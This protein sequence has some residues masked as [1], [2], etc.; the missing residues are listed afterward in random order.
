MKNASM[1]LAVLAAG[2]AAIQCTPSDDQTSKS[3]GRDRPLVYT[4]LYPMHYFAE[5]IAGNSADVEC[6]VA[7]GEDPLHWKPTAED[8]QKLQSADLIVLNG[9]GAEGWTDTLALPISRITETAAVFRKRFIEIEGAI[10]HSHGPGD[11]HTHAGVDPYTWIDPQNALIQAK[12]V[13]AGFVHAMPEKGSDIAQRLSLLIQDL[14]KLDAKC[15]AMGEQPAGEA[16]VASYAAYNYLAQRYGWRVVNLT[17]DPTRVLTDAELDKARQELDGR[18]ARY[19]LWGSQ[20]TTELA[21]QVRRELGLESILFTPCEVLP[22][23]GERDYLGA[24][25]D[26]LD[27]L[28]VAFGK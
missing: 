14:Q 17:L 18:H 2:V 13:A 27:R 9:A 16:L 25:H 4:V 1:L 26:N 22:A 5:R 11:T 6:L 15:K 20:P 10:V 8:V 12:E 3:G 28:S 7:T 21:D 19:L 23:D 24:M